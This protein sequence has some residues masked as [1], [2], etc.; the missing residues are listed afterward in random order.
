MISRLVDQKGLDLLVEVFTDLMK[1]DIQLAV[2]GTGDAKYHTF[3]TRAAE[4]YPGRVGV[5]LAF[6]DEL[7]HWIEAGS[8]LF[9]M[10]S[11]HEPGGISQLEA[12]AAG[13]L[14]V[15]RAT[16]GLRDTV[17]PIRV[18][19]DVVEGNGFLFSDYNSW[20]FYDAIKKKAVGSFRGSHG[21]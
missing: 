10:P 19:G 18:R 16:G 7:A 14:V 13:N 15:A 8:D 17:F 5:R 12:F 21:L 1:L 11:M 4:K 2:L 6:D 3:L 9:L 20:A